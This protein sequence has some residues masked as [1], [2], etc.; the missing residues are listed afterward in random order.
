MLWAV[1]VPYDWHLVPTVCVCRFFLM[2]YGFVNLACALQTILRSPNWRPRFRFYHWWLD[3]HGHKHLFFRW[4]WL[5]LLLL[6]FLLYL[7]Q[8][9]ALCVLSGQNR[10]DLC[11]G[12]YVIIIVCCL[13]VSNFAQKLPNGF[14]WNFQQKAGNRPMNKWLNFGGDLICGLDTG[15]VFRIRHYWEIWNV[16]NRHRPIHQIGGLISQ[17]W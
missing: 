1:I 11:Q 8:T 13:F 16:V 9:C 12:G 14:A 3:T 5:F 6:N 4:I 15:I 2:C 10:T 7:L 17:H